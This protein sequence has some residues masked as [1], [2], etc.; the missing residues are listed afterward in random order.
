MG[1]DCRIFDTDAQADRWCEDPHGGPLRRASSTAEYRHNR[2]VGTSE[3]VAEQVQEFV[4]AGCSEFVLWLRDHPSDE[5]LRRFMS[6]VVP[7]VHPAARE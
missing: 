2:L 7:L 3:Q 5:T 6:E 1:P 4:D